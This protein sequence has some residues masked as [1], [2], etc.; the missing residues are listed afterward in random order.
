MASV[1]LFGIVLGS[2]KGT[3]SW[4][5]DSICRKNL[6]EGLWGKFLG[7]LLCFRGLELLGKEIVGE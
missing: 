2:E 7:K 1:L 6:V 4:L 3:Q 5:E